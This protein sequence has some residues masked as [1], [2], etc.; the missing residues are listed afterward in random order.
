MRARAARRGL[1]ADTVTPLTSLAARGLYDLG[2]R[3][4]FRYI[5]R[6][7][8]DPD[9]RGRL[10]TNLTRRELGGI[11]DEGVDVGPVQYYSTRYA[12]TGAGR[13]MSRA[14]GATV[15]AA[16]VHN[17]KALGLPRRITSWHDLEACPR[18]TPAMM[19]AECNGASL[20]QQRGH[21]PMGLYYGAGL[22]SKKTGYLTGRRLYGLPRVRAYWRAASKVPQIP[23][24]GCTITQGMEVDS[25]IWVRQA[26]T[27][28]S[29]KDFVRVTIRVDFDLIALDHKYKRHSDR[30]LVVAA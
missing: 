4:V 26:T 30:F 11:L 1:A 23:T 7:E 22:G 18:A 25:H 10:G 19:V 29:A 12:S 3:T 15:G 2:V 8:C 21:Y 16:A 17:C 13:Y 9:S 24:R 6:V 14:L 27:G 28:V 5:D 20:V